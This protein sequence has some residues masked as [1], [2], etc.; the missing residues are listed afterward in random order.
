[1]ISRY[2]GRTDCHDC[3]GLRLKKE[4]LAIKIGTKN[5]AEVSSMTI[6]EAF[7]FIQNR[8]ILTKREWTIGKQLI[9]EISN[10]L[11]FLINVGVGY[12]S[13]N[14][15]SNSLSGGESQR[16]NL[17]SRLGSSLSWIVICTR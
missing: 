2:K 7:N 8:F 6:D 12:I 13:I 14:R 9:E 10:R 17:A 5:I 4:S 16:I 3:K 11:A 15:L 1:M